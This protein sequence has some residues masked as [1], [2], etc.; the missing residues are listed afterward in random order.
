MCI[1]KVGSQLSMRGRYGHS[2]EQLATKNKLLIPVTFKD[3]N[4]YLDALYKLISP[5]WMW[6]I[7]ARQIT[8]KDILSS[9]CNVIT[10]E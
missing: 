10:H 3:K 5:K 1:E 2:F 6:Q 4:Q 7:D 9:F 8:T